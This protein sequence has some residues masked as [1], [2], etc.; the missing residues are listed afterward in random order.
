MSVLDLFEQQ[1]RIAPD[2]TAL[3]LES[4]QSF[5]YTALNGVA[6]AI[7][8]ASLPS[9]HTADAAP[10][11]CIMMDRHMPLIAAMLAVLKCGA[12]YVPVDPSFPPDRQTHIF[13]H[14]KC[15][16]LLADEESYAAAVKLGVDV[17][18]AIVVSRISGAVI[19]ST[20]QVIDSPC[21]TLTEAR[22]AA[23]ERQGGGAM[24]V[25]Y[26]SGSTGKPKGVEVRCAGVQNI[27]CWFVRELGTG[28]H[29]R[30]LGI[31]TH[32]FDISVLEIYLPLICG[33]ALVLAESATQKNPFRLMDV[34]RLQRV[35][36]FQATPTTYEMLLVAGWI[37]DLSIDCLVGG[38]A[39]RPSLFPLLGACKRLLNVYGPTETT[40]W[41]SCY[42][43]PATAS[44]IP[45]PP[46][47]GSSLVR[48]PI[49]SPISDTVFYLAVVDP[50]D[51]TKLTL[52]EQEGELLIG[53]IGVAAGYLHA[54]D[55]TAGRFISN[56]FGSGTVYR[57]GDLVQRLP[58][59]EYVF[60]KRLDDQ[61]KID[62]FRI[63]L[64][65]IENVYL[66]YPLVEQA[67]AVV[68]DNKLVLYVKPV[69]DGTLSAEDKQAMREAAGRQLT[70]YMLP[71]YV[72][73][74]KVFPQTANGKLDR[75]ALPKHSEED[76]SE[77]LESVARADDDDEEK[78][79]GFRGGKTMAD[80]ICDVIEAVR[81]RR[82]KSS[83]H[84]TS[85]GVDSLGAVLFI[86]NLSMSL[87]GLALDPSKVYA[88]NVTIAAL[89]RDLHEQL[90]RDNP[91]VLRSLHITRQ[92]EKFDAEMGLGI[93]QE[94]VLAPD[95][96][97]DFENG[98]VSNVR[99]YEGIRG[100]LTF[101]VL[102]DHYHPAYIFAAKAIRIDTALF[103]L[104]S[105]FTSA[106]QLREPPQREDGQLKARASFDLL[107]FIVSRAIGI[108]PI[109]Y[110]C[111]C[112][113]APQWKENDQMR[114]SEGKYS[115]RDSDTCTV[116]YVIGM[117]SWLRPQ[118][119]V[120]GADS[121]V[122]ASIIMNV[123]LIYG[124]SRLLLSNSQSFLMRLN[125]SP[126]L[127]RVAAVTTM[128]A[129]SRPCP[130]VAA[131]M[132]IAAGIFMGVVFIMLALF[133]RYQVSCVWCY[134]PMHELLITFFP[135]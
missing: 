40:I 45:Q 2:A 132:T 16:L 10:L 83:A 109:L 86:R 27:V 18:P 69:G 55:L 71:K 134:L 67:L 48:V 118:C 14:S 60:V 44:A 87:G 42:A 128:L 19:S 24:Y 101:L 111:L 82:P 65:E 38:E 52:S 29:T 64:A 89:G 15:S 125:G 115:Q 130:S 21:C 108:F 70:H 6:E 85:L 81:G 100:V 37:G 32:C 35:S 41:S 129:H 28:P 39:F 13:S 23:A 33:G 79:K 72:V 30:V 113:A 93:E 73:V 107:R 123:F 56:P 68:A 119:R 43:L 98:I 4:G 47:G 133:N 74:L 124:G 53:G 31:T 61:V 94:F 77:G 105:G 34:L 135:L 97:A 126:L 99:L 116:L 1:M 5:S 25:L 75:N 11:V 9:V 17:P 46:A 92:L 114:I 106:M 50:S 36:V 96:D 8:I 127:K 90:Q 76:L 59:G 91:A 57:T 26:T 117:Q 103:V 131:G 120:L 88:Q 104:M 122:Y 62:G 20:V 3:I 121:M 22:K 95:A 110:V 102:W 12:A 112:I 49:G 51:A 78:D 84:F 66:A 80:H 63:E 7:A 58:S 54:P